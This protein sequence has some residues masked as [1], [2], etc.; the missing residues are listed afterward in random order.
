MKVSRVR[1]LLSLIPVAALL[2]AL[3]AGTP[4]YA[5]SVANPGPLADRTSYSAEMAK[6]KLTEHQVSPAT[7]S[8]LDGQMPN[9]GVDT[10]LKSANHSMRDRADCQGSELAALPVKPTA[11]AAYC[12]DTGDSV[13]QDWVPQ[14]LTS[15]GDAD[16]DG[17]WGTNKL[18]LSGWTESS[19]SARVAFID[20]SDPAHLKYRWVLLVIPTDGGN[21]FAR[22]GS[23]VGGMVWF[24][25]NLIV[26][27]RAGDGSNNALYVFSMKHILQA[28]VNS[29][30]VGKVSG[31]FSA[32]G[33]QYVMPAVGSY[34]QP[35]ACTM[36]NDTAIPCF[37]SV[38]LDRT[39]TPFSIVANEWFSSSGG[40]AARI[41]RYELAA[42]GGGMP[43]E[44]SGT[45]TVNA[46]QL[47]KSSAVGL[48]SVLAHAGTYYGA[49]ARGGVGQ[50]GVMWRMRT[51][52]GT[53]SDT[54]GSGDTDNACWA[55][56]SE[57][58]SLWWS[59]QEVWSQ[60]EWAADGSGDPHGTP[61]VPQRVLF[62]VPLS[63][64]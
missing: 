57:G 40:P 24:G 21:N 41:F 13:S 4:A 27:G 51:S 34:S 7:I 30:A 53:T 23:H 60:T 61:V 20:A 5:S 62:S 22:F 63:S 56:H 6:L 47:L 1:V 49:D 14:G 59:T 37:A 29:T 39:T 44:D 10:V 3:S 35:G 54:C 26:T 50:S 42:P 38:S 8:A 55:Q 43:L 25:D 19:T 52:G 16:D 33:Y 36:A 28:Q 45:G 15:S 48:Q 2:A 9:V 12:W 31:G 46:G 64:M 58:I 18:I 11:G 17:M 32:D